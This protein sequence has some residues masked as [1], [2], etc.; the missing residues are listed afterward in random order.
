MKQRRWFRTIA[1]TTLAVAAVAFGVPACGDDDS[2]VPQEDSGA[3]GTP[4][5]D[6]STND[7]NT[8]TDANTNTDAAADADAEAGPLVCKTTEIK[9]NG[10]CVDTRSDP[11]NCGGCGTKCTGTDVCSLSQCT[12]TCAQ[13]LTKCGQACVDTN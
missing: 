1:L 5:V 9:C 2:S 6:S 8:G 4:T 3:D 11:N 13:G 10:A 7:T 12:T